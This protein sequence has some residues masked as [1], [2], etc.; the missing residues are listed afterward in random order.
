[1]EQPRSG[2]GTKN[3]MKKKR[4]VS[5]LVAMTESR[6]SHGELGLLDVAIDR[7]DSR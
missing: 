2:V 1:L 7:G 3:D 6:K 5:A 4:G